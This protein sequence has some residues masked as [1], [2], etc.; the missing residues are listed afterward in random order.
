MSLLTERRGLRV[1][2]GCPGRVFF[3]AWG[4]LWLFFHSKSVLLL[5]SPAHPPIASSSAPAVCSAADAGASSEVEDAGC[6]QCCVELAGK[7]SV[8]KS[9]SWVNTAV[10]SRRELLGPLMV[11]PVSAPS[12]D[13]HPQYRGMFS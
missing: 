13:P 3:P 10:G 6:F 1:S 9:L 8:G 4:A 5:Y 2:P 12:A 7:E 11:G